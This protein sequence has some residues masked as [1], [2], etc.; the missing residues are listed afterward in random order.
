MPPFFKS[1]LW[2]YR[3]EIQFHPTTNGKERVNGTGVP[4]K[5]RSMADAILILYAL[6]ALIVV[7]TP[8]HCPPEKIE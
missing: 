1:V 8:I 7:R 6:T 2:P 5:T 3:H 4:S